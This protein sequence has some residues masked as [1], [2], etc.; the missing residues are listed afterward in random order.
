MEWWLRRLC[1]QLHPGLG[2]HLGY[3]RLYLRVSL[4]VWAH[5]HSRLYSLLTLARAPVAGGQYYWVNFLAPPSARQFLSYLTGWLTLCGWQAAVAEGCYV[6]SSIIQGLVVLGNPDYKP[7]AWRGLLIFWAVLA[8]V[9]AINTL[10]RYVLP[11]FES[12]LLI[13]HIVGFFALLLPLVI[14]APEKQSPSTVFTEFQNLGGW[15]TQ[16]VSFMV[17]ILGSVYAFIG[18]DAAVHVRIPS[19]LKDWIYPLTDESLCRGRCLKKSKA[20]LWWCHGQ[21]C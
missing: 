3:L 4:D 6:C 18:A 19:I 17:G 14:L 20:L 5:L 9:V 21:S 7:T 8:F 1:L 13:V 2:G 15:P 11:R 16:G 12:L 10:G